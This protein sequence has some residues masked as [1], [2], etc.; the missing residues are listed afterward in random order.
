MATYEND[1][2]MYEVEESDYEDGDD[3]FMMVDEEN[4]APVA[5]K[6]A[7]KGKKAANKKNSVLTVRNDNAENVPAKA[8]GKGTKKTK[9]IE[10]TYQ[11]KTQLEHILLRP[12]TYIGST[13]PLETQ[14]FIY[15]GV[16]NA[17]VNKT[18]TYTPGLYK[19]FDESKY[20]YDSSR[21]KMML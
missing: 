10:E 20:D 2:S 3:S 19:I 15:D 21:P 12:D 18:I 7:S 5:K 9:T 16:Q 8:T 1:I 6:P 4:M 14:M 17:I 13:E 11:K